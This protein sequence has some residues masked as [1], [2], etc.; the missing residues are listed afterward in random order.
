MSL[1]ASPSPPGA[2]PL[3]RSAETQ[4]STRR[5]ARDKAQRQRVARGNL[6]CTT[7]HV[8]CVSFSHTPVRHPGPEMA[9]SVHSPINCFASAGLSLENDGSF[10]RRFNMGGK[11]NL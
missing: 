10:G 11:S 4:N 3:S 5:D 9:S 6:S 2:S 8:S 1:L 7:L